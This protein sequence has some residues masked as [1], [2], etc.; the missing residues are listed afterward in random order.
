MIINKKRINNIN[1]IVESIPAGK[2]K[3]RVCYSLQNKEADLDRVGFSPNLIKEGDSILPKRIAPV[4]KFNADGKFISRKD[5]PKESRFLFQR[6]WEW[7]LRDGTP[8]ERVV[9]YYRDC[10]PRD[11]IPAPCKEFIYRDDCLTSEILKIEDEEGLKHTINLFLE[12]FGE[13]EITYEDFTQII[14]Y[15]KRQ[16][17]WQFLPT[18]ENIWESILEHLKRNNIENNSTGSLIIERQKILKSYNP[19]EIVR[20]TGG[21]SE[22]LAYIFP[23]FTLLE[24]VRYGNAIYVFEE[25][26]EELSKLTKAKIISQNL[27]KERIIHC[28]G[29]KEK[30]TQFVN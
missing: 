16:V 22:Y 7:E 8:M 17:N 1:N 13:C 2:N 6:V 27:H 12:F 25:N 3:I 30:I 29:W 20:G 11:L 26:W 4:S 10:Y 19:K 24:S 14:T 5:L 28:T 18:G 21:F 23:N 9:D 15:S